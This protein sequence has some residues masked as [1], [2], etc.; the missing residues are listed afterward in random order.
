MVS[1]PGLLDSVVELKDGVN[2]IFGPSNTGKTYIIKCIDYLFGSNNWPIDDGNGYD[3]IKMDIHSR[4]GGTCTIIRKL[5]EKIV[6]VVDNTIENIEEGEY[7]TSSEKFKQLFLILIGITNVVSLIAKQ[8][9]SKKQKLT[10]RTLGPMFLIPEEN[11]FRSDSIVTTPGFKNITAALSALK[12]CYDGKQV[13][14]PD[15]GD[16]NTAAISRKAIIAYITTQLHRLNEEKQRLKETFVKFENI[17]IDELLAE[18]TAKLEQLYKS[19]QELSNHS[20]ILLQSKI[21]VSDKLRELVYMQDRYSALATCYQSDID[22]LEFIID[23]ET[24]R[25]KIA[26]QTKCPFCS[27]EIKLK[28]H[29]TLTGSAQKELR[30]IKTQLQELLMLIKSND[31]EIQ[32]FQIQLLNIENE[33]T[34]LGILIDT[35]YKTQVTE[36]QGKIHELE[37]LQSMASRLEYIEEISM[38]LNSDMQDYEMGKEKLLSYDAKEML[39][40]SFYDNFNRYFEEALKSCKYDSFIS[41][42]LSKSDFDIIVDGKKKRNQGKGYRAFLNTVMAYCILKLLTLNGMYSP[43][44]LILDSPILSLKE[45]DEQTSAEMKE[46]LFKMI[47]DTEFSCQIIIVENNIPAVDYSKANLIRFTKDSSSGRFGFLKHS[48]Y[49]RT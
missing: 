2:I 10:W 16:A 22:R 5:N 6:S 17:N 47:I 13:A 19:T 3:T 26:N 8:D 37:K 38:K 44:L 36:T 9:Y 48:D 24:L 45:K 25:P 15:T 35:T 32:K 27:G 23:G 43:G 41:C 34:A 42:C 1:G 14:V 28:Q 21:N 29:K 12:Y 4:A 20:K 46:S 33:Y 31:E 40:D 30:N 49:Q 7:S 39:G 11:I 18:Q